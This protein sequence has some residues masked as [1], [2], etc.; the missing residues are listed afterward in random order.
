MGFLEAF[1]VLETFGA[2]VGLTAKV[3]VDLEAEIDRVKAKRAK[4]IAEELNLKDSTGITNSVKWKCSGLDIE[5]A[6]G[7]WIKLEWRLYQQ[8]SK[9]LETMM[10]E[11]R[12]LGPL[13]SAQKAQ[14]S[15]STEKYSKEIESTMV[16]FLKMES[17]SPEQ[18][19]E[20][21]VAVAITLLKASERCADALS[22]AERLPWI[23]F[24]SLGMQSKLDEIQEAVRIQREVLK[25]SVACA[26]SL[27]Q[28]QE[29]AEEQDRTEEQE[30]REGQ[31]IQDDEELAWALAESLKVSKATQDMELERL[32]P[33]SVHEGEEASTMARE[34]GI[35]PMVVPSS[36]PKDSR[37]NGASIQGYPLEET[38]SKIS[39][40]NA[41]GDSY[42]VFSQSRQPPTQARMAAVK[43]SQGQLL[44]YQD[45]SDANL[46][47]SLTGNGLNNVDNF[48]HQFDDIQDL[49][50]EKRQDSDKRVKIAVIGSGLD[51]T[52]P[53][54]TKLVTSAKEWKNP[55]FSYHSMISG[56]SAEEDDWGHG[57]HSIA[58]LARI[59]PN[60]EILVVRVVPKDGIVDSEHIRKGIEYA[61]SQG[62]NII[63]LSLSFPKEQERIRKALDEAWSKNITV[64]AVAFNGARESGMSWP[65]S[66]P[67]VFGI[68]ASDH[69]GNSPSSGPSSTSSLNKMSEY[70]TIGCNVL[71]AWP[72]SL[73]DIDDETGSLRGAVTA[74]DEG[75]QR[76]CSG[77]STSTVVAAGIAALIIEF[78]RQNAHLG[79]MRDVVEGKPGRAKTLET[80]EGMQ[81]AFEKLSER[82]DDGLRFL[83]PWQRFR[84]MYAGEPSEERSQRIA[85]RLADS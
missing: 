78:A 64:F 38:M 47:P 59:A 55:R 79:C 18:M 12:R 74:A 3:D 8:R 17:L 37:G 36:I 26:D 72:Q 10:N 65:A 54:V 82:H 44:Q 43:R 5:N 68:H 15:V 35:P 69:E 48:F 81:G 39:V 80:P 45:M 6:N 28:E 23:V 20:T 41:L 21:E 83:V 63:S 71:S 31:S 76:R 67:T 9:D 58:L 16:D 62:A 53:Q 32:P 60:A 4:A 14:M 33:Y 50:V 7:E 61:I 46:R 40:S 57:T 56:V 27:R 84:P 42:R 19:A 29:G 52:H 25:I 51:S 66:Y 13:S 11:V 73:M 77:T 22:Q 30:R 85:Y 34:S 2:S 75:P 49:L 70:K 1:T 24:V